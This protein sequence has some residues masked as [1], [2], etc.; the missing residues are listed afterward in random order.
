M[1]ITPHQ[2]IEQLRKRY[3]TGRKWTRLR[4]RR[5]RE[6]LY[7][8]RRG[9]RYHTGRKWTR[10]RGRRA[11]NDSIVGGEGKDTIL[12]GNGHDFVDGGAGNDSIVGGEGEDTLLG[13]N[14]NDSIYGEGDDLIYGGLGDDYIVPGVG[15][16]TVSGGVGNDVYE[17]TAR[18]VGE[19]LITITDFQVGKD[20]IKIADEQ[21]FLDDA[22][23]EYFKSQPVAQ[24]GLVNHQYR[25]LEIRSEKL[26][27]HW[28]SKVW[29]IGSVERPDGHVK[30]EN[31]E[32]RAMWLIGKSALANVPGVEDGLI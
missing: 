14:G 7:R 6:R 11:G 30:I 25:V 27:V 1:E 21:Q 28:S 24:W 17:L 26:A 29:V 32:K 20:Q 16:S 12:G 10:L 22:V 31:D 4:G 2:H 5:G 3:H 13:G 8:R 19:S 23:D 9:K 15:S 18:R